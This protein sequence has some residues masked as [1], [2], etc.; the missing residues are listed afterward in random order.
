[1][2]CGKK[3]QESEKYICV[4]YAMKDLW[5]GLHVETMLLMGAHPGWARTD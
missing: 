1:M 5:E 3:F 2:M 4:N